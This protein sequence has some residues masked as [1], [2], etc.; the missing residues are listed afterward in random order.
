MMEETPLNNQDSNLTDDLVNDLTESNP[1]VTTDKDDYAPGETAQITGSGFTPGSEVVIQIVDD[2]ADPGDDGDV[3]VYQPITIIADE[4][5]SFSTTWFV[6]IDNNG[7]GSGIPDALNATLFLTATGTGADGVLGTGDDQLATTTFSD[8]GRPGSNNTGSS[9]SGG[10]VGD[11]NLPGGGGNSDT[12]TKVSITLVNDVIDD[13]ESDDD[14]LG[15]F[16]GA[17]SS[18]TRTGH[19]RGDFNFVN[20]DLKAE[21][22]FSNISEDIPVPL[23][24]G[25]PPPAP[26]PELVIIE[27]TFL[28]D[29]GVERERFFLIFSENSFP[30]INEIPDAQTLDNLVNNLPFISANLFS[31]YPVLPFPGFALDDDVSVSSTTVVIPTEPVATDNT[32]EVI[33]DG[34]TNPSGNLITNNDGAGVDFVP[35]GNSLNVSEIDGVSDPDIDII[36]IF[37]NLDW[38]TDGSYTYRL[39]NDDSVIQSLS[40]NETRTETFTY[41]LIGDGDSTDTADLTI[42]IF[43]DNDAPTANN[44]S[45]TGFITDEDTAFTTVSVLSNDIDPDTNDTLF[46]YGIDTSATSGLVTD[47]GDGT[48]NYNPN[49][50]FEDLNDGE[51]DTDTFSY[52]INDNRS[53]IAT[54]TVTI[55]ITGVNDAPIANDDEGSSLTTDEK[56]AFTTGNVLINDTDVEGDTLN[57]TGIDT[58][59]TLGTVTNNGDGTFSYD[60]NGLFKDLN[61]GE[62]AT[63]TFSYTI[64]DGFLT[65]TA[66]VSITIDGV[67]DLNLNGGNGQDTLEAGE[68]D[69][70]LSGKNGSDE[71][72]GLAGDDILDGGNGNDT[73]NGGAGNDTLSGKN[74]ADELSGLAGDDILDGNKG[75][76]LLDGGLGNDTLT[77]GNGSDMFILAAGEGTDTITDFSS[78]DSIGLSGGIGFN[79]LSFS[80]EDIILTSTS[81]VLAI[82]TGIDTNTLVAS[83]FTIV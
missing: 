39:N 52:T 55:E 69:D 71:L 4:F 18:Y 44:D 7:T 61:T 57:V 34:F 64:S 27:Y 6:P 43:G 80:G 51:S 82:L 74:G 60:P 78:P 12:F 24:D 37:G 25:L 21:L 77:G 31:T 2:P 48:F 13:A 65:D 29:G 67:T 63:D 62:S 15:L 23:E 56:T 32:A 75:S 10:I 17:V 42:T 3:D 11:G 72:S 22:V 50:Q 76:D 46:L 73:L 28:D 41:T 19:S 1:T 83:D 40:F 20:L 59:G 8:A 5:G 30:A 9:N 66:T 45:G 53:I 58:T 33:E 49:G 14:S 16:P 79:D 47:N 81:E 54:A 38:N 35:Q 70:T 26:E 36:G 68:G